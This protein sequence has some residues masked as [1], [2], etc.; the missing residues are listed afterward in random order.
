MKIFFALASL[1]LLSGCATSRLTVVT[2]EGIKVTIS[3]PK[4]M[5][6][7]ATNLRSPLFSA[8]RLTIHTDASG[9]VKEKT[10][11]VAAVAGAVSDT[12]KLFAPVP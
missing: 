5:E 11:G 10:V 9:V 4:N 6:F 8:D 3:L 7:D 2:P 1:V 12:A